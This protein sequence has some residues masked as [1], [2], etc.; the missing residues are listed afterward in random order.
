MSV[1]A[2][3]SIGNRAE[4]HWSARALLRAPYDEYRPAALL[5]HYRSRNGAHFFPV[6][7]TDETQRE[8]ID[9]LLENRFEFNAETHELA[10]PIAWAHN[11]SSDL[12]WHILLH[13]WYYAVGLGMAYTDTG[14]ACY[15]HKWLSLT[16]SWIAAA[17]PDFVVNETMRHD[18]A[19]VTGRRIQNWIYAYYYFVTRNE[20]ANVPVEFH[21]R[22]LV[23]LHEQVEWL[24]V[25][26]SPKGNHRTL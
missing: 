20:Q 2:V 8:K 5:E 13:K 17:P 11:P 4:T 12:E 18:V 21:D 26:L 7:D 9:A 19:Q 10:E 6:P 22:F 3:V 24:R 16:T 1:A 25:H 14:D 15:L 23:S